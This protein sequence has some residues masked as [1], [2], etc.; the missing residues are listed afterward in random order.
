MKEN[1]IPY[2]EYDFKPYEGKRMYIHYNQFKREKVKQFKNY[3]HNKRF[4]VIA[5]RRHKSYIPG[6]GHLDRNEDKIYMYHPP[7]G[8]EIPNDHLSEKFMQLSY[9]CVL[10]KSEKCGDVNART[11]SSKFF[12]LSFHVEAADEIRCY[13]Y[14]RGQISRFYPKVICVFCAICIL[15]IDLFVCCVCDV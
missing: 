9:D 8:N 4:C 15:D 11:A 14:Q 1:D 3:P 6:L 13:L 10:P 5:D 12:M 2:H 7:K